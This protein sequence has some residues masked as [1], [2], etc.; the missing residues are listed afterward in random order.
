MNVNTAIKNVKDELKKVQCENKKFNNSD[1]SEKIKD[2]KEYI[3]EV[4]TSRDEMLELEGTLYDNRE[5]MK[6]KI[7]FCY[8]RLSRCYWDFYEN[9][10]TITDSLERYNYQENQLKEFDRL[11]LT[12]I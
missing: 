10:E 11:R 5:F 7:N 9:C 8:Q 1:V 12:E 4:E 3:R 6:R 2:V